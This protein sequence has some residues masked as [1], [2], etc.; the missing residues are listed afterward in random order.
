MKVEFVGGPKNNIEH[1]IKEILKQSDKISIAVA[2]LENSGVAI[3]R[4]SI[5]ELK[6]NKPSISIITGSVNNLNATKEVRYCGCD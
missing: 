4:Q 1:K 5:K 2:F 6:K 3:L